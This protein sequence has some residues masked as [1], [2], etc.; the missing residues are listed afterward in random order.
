MIPAQTQKVAYTVLARVPPINVLHFRYG[1]HT[2]G[3]AG[4]IR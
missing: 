1:Q 4:G 3:T 2:S